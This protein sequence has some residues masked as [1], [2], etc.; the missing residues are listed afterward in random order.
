MGNEENNGH[1]AWG[2]REITSL[3]I[4][5]IEDIKQTIKIDYFF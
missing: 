2:K 3:I 4:A 5:K 1:A